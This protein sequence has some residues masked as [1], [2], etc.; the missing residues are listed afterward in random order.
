[1]VKFVYT[2]TTDRFPW[3]LPAK[4]PV[5]DALPPVFGIVNPSCPA[6]FCR[7]LK[8]ENDA[9]VECTDFGV[10]ARVGAKRF[11]DTTPPHA[12]VGDRTTSVRPPPFT[13]LTFDFDVVQ[14]L[15]WIVHVIFSG[16]VPPLRSGGEREID[17]VTF[18]YVT[19]PVATVTLDLAAADA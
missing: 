4:D 19:L 11:E 18:R 10:H 12:F 7:K 9:E 17:P 14:A 5:T 16:F 13:C 8:P 3:S 6:L 2:V 15:A 1:M